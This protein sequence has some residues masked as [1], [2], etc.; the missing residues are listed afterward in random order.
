MR[1]TSTIRAAATLALALALGLVGPGAVMGAPDEDWPMFGHDPRHTGTTT[2]T[3]LAA[4][5]AGSLNLQWQTNLGQSIT[6]SPAVVH[7]TT[8]GKQVVYLADSSGTVTAVDGQ[9]GE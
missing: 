9:N 1:R 7:N 6:A 3:G 5:T 4:S 8:L 2:D